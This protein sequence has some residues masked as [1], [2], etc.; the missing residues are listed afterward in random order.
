MPGD[1]IIS[2]KNVSKAYRIWSSPSARLGS[3]LAAA[4]GALFPRSSAPHLALTARA[5]RGYRDFHAL[6]D[7]SF[8]IRRGEATGIIGRNGSG[9]STLLQLIA[10]TL[11]VTSGSLHVNGRVSALLELGS[12]FNPEF[13]GRENVFL[14][15]SIYG[16][17]RPEMARRFDEIAAFADI[18]DF[19][20]QPVKTYSSGM[21]MRLAFAV[22]VSVQPDILIVDEAL[23]VGDVFFTQKCFQRIREIVHRGA[24]LIFVSHDTG[25]VQ[26]LC[27][28]GLLLSQGK[29]VHDGAPEDCVSRYFN[30]HQPTTASA[31]GPVAAGHHAPVAPNLRTAL[32]AADILPSAK[33]RH[34]DRKLE[35]IAAAVLD[36]HGAATWDF[37]LLHRATI[38]VL[39]KAHAPIALPSVGLQ[40]HDR[41]GNLLFA[42]GNSQLRFPLPPLAAG[43]EI[44]LDFR[45]TLT[46]Q[47][48]L[49]T[50]SLDAA[51]A[52]PTDPNVGTF[53]DRVG[54]LG[55]LSVAHHAAGV[56]PFYGAAQL[57]L[58]ISYA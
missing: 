58:E 8:E 14:N 45:V 44:M 49:Y 19:I 50:L 31:A 18:G 7:I 35:L 1:V 4:A 52:D 33:S 17:S 46:A 48:G 2:A 38:R 9:K 27:D 25:S 37:E 55:P 47:A 43:E 29:L 32:V 12:G 56:L 36:G 6:D 16:L 34:G 13:T 22:A 39:F 23:S 5:A 41:M 10:G 40:L 24:T 53:H 3:P 57:P 15:G 11:A 42:A 51:E 54:G 26:N 28:R 30:L 21:M 20:E